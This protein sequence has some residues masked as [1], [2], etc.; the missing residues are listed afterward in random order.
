MAE[1]SE[2]KRL[3][4]I[5]ACD[6]VESGMLVGLGT[7]STVRYTIL[8]L[9]KR[10]KNDGLK[11]KGVPTSLATESLAH[12]IGIPLIELPP[13]KKLDII[14]DGADEFDLGF[15][16]IKGGGGAL[17]REKIVAQR[18]LR[19]IVV[20]DQSK[21]VNTLGNFPLPIEVTPFAHECTMNEIKEILDCEVI[22]RKVDGNI[23]NTDNDNF[24]LDA[25]VGPKIDDPKEIESKL[26]QIPGVVQVGLFVN[27][28]DD[29]VLA[30][31]DGIE[32][33]SK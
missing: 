22:I 4:G 13:D 1:V 27:M 30:T 5:R 21:Q 16:L 12:E 33:L 6:F 25:H 19:M 8:E 15:N 29:V 10:M 28:C 17:L 23:F 2:L 20:A 24:I 11:I 26:L 32:V 31:K 9:G 14:I 18:A 3:A 7:G